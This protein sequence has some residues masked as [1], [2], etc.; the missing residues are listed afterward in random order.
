M[1]LIF[2]GAGPGVDPPGP[3]AGHSPLS[4][5]GQQKTTVIRLQTLD[6][7]WETVG[8]DRLR[9][10][11]PEND[12]YKSDEWGPSTCS[13]D[14]KRD[15]GTIFPDLSAWT[16]I[17]VE[18]GGVPVWSGRVK[19]TP[20]GEAERTVNVQGKGWQ[21]HLDDDQ[22]QHTYAH[23]KLGD[24]RDIR[25]F[26]T[27]D[28]SVYRAGP[29]VNADRGVALLSFPANAT[30]ANLTGC[31]ILLDL[32]QSVG[33]TLMVT[34][35]TQTARGNIYV[36][37]L[38]GDS[39]ALLGVQAQ[40]NFGVTA[41]GRTLGP[42]TAGGTF[43]YCGVRLHSAAGG[44]FTDPTDTFARI[45]SIK[46]WANASYQSAGES[47]LKA[48]QIIPDA[49]D[50]ATILLSDD[51]SAIDPGG[52]VTFAFPE[53]A[54]QG[55]KTPREVITAAN[56]VHDY[57]TQIDVRRRMIFAPKPSVPRI[58]IGAWPGSVF[59]DA[60]ANDGEEIYN[61]VVVEGAGADG[62]PLTIERA[63]GQQSGVALQAISS[64]TPDNPSFATNTA[65][66]TPS[67]G[68]TITRDTVTTHSAPASGAWDAGATGLQT[69]N[70]LTETFS[71]SF[72]QGLTYVLRF[73]ALFDDVDLLDSATIRFGTAAD[74]A[75]AFIGGG[76][77]G[78]Q[79]YSVAW[80]PSA[81]T[82][83]VTAVFSFRKAGDFA[84]TP[85]A[86]WIDS[87]TLFL[88]TPT[89]VDRR[90]FRRT[91]TLPVKNS[92][93]PELGRQIGDVWLAAHKTTPLKGTVK[94][95]G[96]RATRDIK[97]GAGFPPEQ[98]LMMTGELLRLAHRIDPDTGGQGR[99]G[100]IAEV[101][102]TPATDTAVVAIDS[103]RT[104]HEALLER[105]A[106]VVG[107]G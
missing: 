89:L 31:A 43:R 5:T 65:S 75:T 92:L 104:S 22:Y 45:T 57:R 67:G 21:Y 77:L 53:F 61:R 48:T 42:V 72:V 9:G 54:L 70:T 73:S 55:Q 88:A 80:T 3:D 81:T 6:G 58:E 87:L 39:P 10:V 8:S 74:S 63:A 46:V 28:L 4:A 85:T 76:V 83:G 23:A 69:G 13:F 84:S 40:D 41:T 66:W 56:A 82:S 91:H 51:R 102:Y 78:F 11:W 98:L 30:V 27:A 20:I 71:G 44:P 49:L 90:G 79:G 17:E 95:T 37:L 94:I 32:G 47:V 14:L 26:P 86:M 15:P 68:T 24:Y 96:N 52:T 62:A 12:S 99:D 25:T 2:W 106:V 33:R 93:T 64:P 34:Y 103:R 19:E 1:S 105:L 60:S 36:E 100:R 50:R 97:T 16:P 101:T 29:Q 7:V 38:A 59:D 18:I 35:D 107:S